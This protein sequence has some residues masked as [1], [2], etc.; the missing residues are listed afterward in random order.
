VLWSKHHLFTSEVQALASAAREG[1]VPMADQSGSKSK[2]RHIIIAG[3]DGSLYHLTPETLEKHKID[4]SHPAHAQAQKLVAEQQHGVIQ[5]AE[6]TDTGGGGGGGTGISAGVANA[7]VT[8]NGGND[9][10]YSMLNS[11]AVQVDD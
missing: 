11:A 4:A 8:Y 6:L 9:I 7:A 2:Q 5:P 3:D 10:S 1:F